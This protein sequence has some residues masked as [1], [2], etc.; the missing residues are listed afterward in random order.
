MALIL[1]RDEACM[2]CRVSEVTPKITST[3]VLVTHVTGLETLETHYEYLLNISKTS[4][5][6]PLIISRLLPIL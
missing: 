4:R 6:L 5:F 1:P 2:K 3:N